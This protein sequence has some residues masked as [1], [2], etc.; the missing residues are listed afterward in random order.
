MPNLAFGLHDRGQVISTTP[1]L[2]FTWLGTVHFVGLP[3]GEFKVTKDIATDHHAIYGVGPESWT[4][5]VSPWSHFLIRPRLGDEKAQHPSR[6]VEAF[7]LPSW[8]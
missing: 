5:G 4:G 8:A 6:D 2:S 7:E 1:S 3:S